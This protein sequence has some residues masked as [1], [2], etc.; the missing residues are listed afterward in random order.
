MDEDWE[1]AADD[2]W[3]DVIGLFGLGLLLVVLLVLAA[4]MTWEIVQYSDRAP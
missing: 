2:D 3:I 1:N 4:W